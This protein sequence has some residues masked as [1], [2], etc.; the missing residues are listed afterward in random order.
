MA[1]RQ[2]AG[3]YGCSAT[4]REGTRQRARHLRA[5][6]LPD[7]TLSIACMWA[8]IFDQWRA[9]IHAGGGVPLEALPDGARGHF[10]HFSTVSSCSQSIVCNAVS[11][12]HDASFHPS[13][14]RALHVIVFGRREACRTSNCASVARAV[15]TPSAHCTVRLVFKLSKAFLHVIYII[16][17]LVSSCKHHDVGGKQNRKV[18]GLYKP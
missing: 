5:G 6:W 2:V 15:T 17:R 8:G 13:T 3:P 7:L 16:P 18:I 9:E 12:S 1:G 4:L 10:L 14:R 11:A